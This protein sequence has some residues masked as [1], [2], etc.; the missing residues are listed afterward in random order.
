[1]ALRWHSPLQGFLVTEGAATCLPTML[2]EGALCP[3]SPSNRYSKHTPR[4]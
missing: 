4:G 1:M 3:E 2:K